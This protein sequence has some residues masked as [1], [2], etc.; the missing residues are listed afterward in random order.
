MKQI[1]PDCKKLFR[2]AVW[3]LTVSPAVGTPLAQQVPDRVSGRVVDATGGAIAGATVTVTDAQGNPTTVTTNSTGSY[4]FMDL[5]PGQYTVSAS[6]AG[7][8]PYENPA[9]EIAAG[10]TTILPILLS[11]AP[12]K[13]E[14]TIQPAQGVFRNAGAVVL[15]GDEFEALPDDPDDL[16]ADLEALA[17]SSAGPQG[18]Q[19]FVD[20]FSGARLP[21]KTSIR[22]FRTNQNPFSAAYD[23]VGFGRIEVFT[24]PGADKLRG[25]VFFNFGHAIFNS[26]NPFYPSDR[27]LI[28]ERFYGGNFSGPLHKRASFSVDLER[29]EIDTKAVIN[30]TLLDSALNL[31]PLSR[32][33][34]TPQSRLSVGPRL[35]YQWS[36]NH[37]LVGRY[38]HTRTG[39][40]N[41]GI[42]ELS[43]P[44]RAYDT[45]ETEHGFQLTETAVLGSRLINE[46]RFQFVRTRIGQFGDNSVPTLN[47]S[48]AFTGGGAEIGRSS[49]SQNRWETQ[50][51]TY[52]VRGAH[53]LRWGARLRGTTISDVSPLNFGGTFRFSSGTGPQLD[54]DNQVVQDAADQP[55]LVPMTALERYRRTILFQGQGLTGEQIRILGGGASQFSLTAGNSQ[56]TVSQVDLGL[57]VQDDWRVRPNFLLSAGLRYETQNNIRHWTDFAPRIGF[58]WAPGA[59]KQPKTAVRT[60]FGIFYD[61]FSEKLTLQAIRLNGVQQQQYV[62]RN[63]D[64]F[65]TVPPLQTLTAQPA[66]IRRV[67]S[68]LRAPY[69]LQTAIAIERLLPF[70]TKIT[71]TF[72]HSHGLHLL[73]SRNINAPVPGTFTPGVSTS[74]IRPYGP[75]NIFLYESVGILKQNQWNTNVTSRFHRNVTLFALYVLNYAN[76]NTDGP[77]TFPSDPYDDSLEYGRS[78]L[79]ERHRFVL[80]ASVLAPAGFQFSPFIVARAGT[81]FNI[82]TGVDTNGDTLFTERPAFAGGLSSPGV[83]TT[84]FGVFDRDPF[85]G[86]EIIP[87]NYGSTP[88]YFTM[89]LRFSKAFGFGP[90]KSKGSKSE[91]SSGEESGVK[92]IL[93]DTL[94]EKRYNL[95]I[96]VSARNLFNRTNPGTPVGSLISPL[97]GSSNS[98]ADTYAPAPGAGN[99]RVE[100]QLRFKF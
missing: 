4:I 46:T 23:R 42:G 49:L 57:F 29:R 44:E 7:F 81:P 32:A 25:Q 26:R 28:W 45:L 75:G 24:K 66:T 19:M 41:A 9:V 80:G 64:F 39:R 21:P 18:S 56:A 65:P 30:A 90:S 99:R 13:Q 43:L 73:R 83:V 6:F 52:F 10:R 12:I 100:V 3:F 60:G 36:P 31:T 63:P 79:D 47:V 51:N 2:I 78:S 53:S 76:S 72:T 34:G 93:K 94:T 15:P 91:T 97:F 54:A 20:G 86:E 11:L 5:P 68:D 55:V 69:I 74:G 8:A 1:F 33:I 58:A 62:V 16:A 59:S 67:A 27:P 82:T 87:R 84:H 22:E 88:A 77:A 89:N 96:A 98:L 37:T 85:T 48:D 35:D 40:D 50:N 17:G 95:A 71:S 61:R 70:N 14:V 38:T 92:S